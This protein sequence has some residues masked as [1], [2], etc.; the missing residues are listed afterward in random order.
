MTNDPLRRDRS[1]LLDLLNSYEGNGLVIPP[2]DTPRR[3]VETAVA[4]G[5]LSDMGGN[6]YMISV[7]GIGALED[8][9]LRKT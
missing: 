9:G 5:Y 7:Q 3:I 6:R 4:N 1:Q 8:A 2:T